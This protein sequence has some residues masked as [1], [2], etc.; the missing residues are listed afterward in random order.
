MHYSYHTLLRRV[1]YYS[2]VY[3]SWEELL[4]ETKPAARKPAQVRDVISRVA[5]HTTHR[6]C[7]LRLLWLL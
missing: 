4:A 3:G 5:T 7:V 2:G 6:R 1:Y